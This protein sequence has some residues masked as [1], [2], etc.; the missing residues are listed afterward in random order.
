MQTNLIFSVVLDW[1]VTKSK[2]EKTA[3]DYVIRLSTGDH[4]KGVCY[5]STRLRGIR[6][7]RVYVQRMANKIDERTT[8]LLKRCR[9]VGPKNWNKAD[10]ELSPIGL[11]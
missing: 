5:K 9:G 3:Y 10:T 2:T 1:T 4:I 11:S 6:D 8:I 7:V